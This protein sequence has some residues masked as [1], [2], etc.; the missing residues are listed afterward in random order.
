MAE[1]NYSIT[2]VGPGDRYMKTL[3]ED[4]LE[5]EG[6]HLDKNLDY[7]A[8][9]LD[10]DYNVIATGSCF[11][12]T[13]RCMA[14]SS[15]HQGEALMNDIVSHLIEYQFSRGNYHIFL[16]TKCNTAL[17]FNSL[18][19]KEIARMEECNIV[20]MENK[21]TGFRDYLENLKKETLAQLQEMDF[22]K[23][24]AYEA[25]L[26][27]ET[28]SASGANT[29]E[30][31]G[32]KVSAIVMNANPF[33]LGHRYLVEKAM[34]NCDILHLF[35]VSEDAS[36]VPFSVRRKLIEEGTA[37]LKGII[38]HDSGS[39]IIS[40]ATFPAYFQ[41][42]DN[43]VIKSQAGIDLHVFEGIAKKLL[44][45]SRF[46]G[47]EPTSLV[48]G[49]YNDIMSE[50]LPKAGIE[51][52]I[53][54]RKEHDGKTISA[55]AVRKAIHDGELDS[56]KDLVPETTYKYFTSDEAKSVIEKIISETDVIHY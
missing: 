16:Y 48:T 2:S 38:Y 35:M 50:A 51:C 15:D 34:E 27:N 54:P 30:A 7:T 31:S 8:A 40:S 18:G 45:N 4:L 28:E 56:I 46:V 55:S 6:I 41:K 11:G 52:H 12:N 3:V 20:F 33:T 10:D 42:G 32:L 9:M 1:A 26:Q 39:Y 5:K 37:D 13:L 43:A 21:R 22:D 23:A 47:D 53:V 19:F 24:K 44:I 14:V 25:K 49:I 17:F 36:L 29:V